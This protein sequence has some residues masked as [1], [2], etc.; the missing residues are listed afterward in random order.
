MS[1]NQLTTDYAYR[2]VAVATTVAAIL[3]CVNWLYRLHPMAPLVRIVPRALLG[4]AVILTVVAAAVPSW[5]G[6]GTISACVCAFAAMLI[7]T[8]LPEAGRLL[9]GVAGIGIGVASIG[10]GIDVLLNGKALLSSF[11]LICGV[12]MVGSGVALVLARLNIA[13]IAAVWLGIGNA[14]VG[15]ALALQVSVSLGIAFT[16]FGLA[17]IWIGIMQ[18]AERR[19]LSSAAGY[20]LAVG[21]IGAGVT[22]VVD[23]APLA[24]AVVIA[25]GLATAVFESALLAGRAPL[26]GIAGIALGATIIGG[27]VVLFEY[28]AVLAGGA[29]AVMGIALICLGSAL[30]SSG[31]APHFTGWLKSLTR[32]P[33]VKSSPTEGAP[34]SQ[35]S[36]SA[37][38]TNSSPTQPPD[39]D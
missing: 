12:G 24:G 28:H 26:L 6:A 37:E 3:I 15:V 30:F 31:T 2:G 22:L 23:V 34:G 4:L 9:G 11:V 38:G 29:I 25:F 1:V 10:N 14:G 17:S 7:H 27:A 39:T 36:A 16:I 33:N 13:W 5:E 32:A 18:L 20:G 35:S 19:K 21:A 8:E